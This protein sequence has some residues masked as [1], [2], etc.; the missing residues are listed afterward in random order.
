M[1]YIALIFVAIYLFVTPSFAQLVSEMVEYHPAPGQLVNTDEAGSVRAARSVIGSLNGLVSLGAYG[2]SVVYK[3]NQP[4][5]NDQNNP[6]GVDFVI[7][8]N[9][10]SDWAEPGIVMVMKDENQ[11]GLADDHW[12]ELAGSD[13][14]FSSTNHHF[15]VSY[16]PSVSGGD[17][18]WISSDSASGYVCSNS[19]H[20]QNYY[21]SSDFFRDDISEKISFSG[22]RIDSEMDFSNPSY[23]KSYQRK[24]G[25]ADN[26]LR[27]NSDYVLPDNP[28]TQVVEGCGGDAMDIGWAVDENG[29]YVDL[30]QI[31]FV[32]IYCG[33]LAN[34]GWMGEISTEICGIADVPANLAINGETECIAISYLPR[35][36][37][38]GV[39]Y[40]LEA[41]A[42]QNGR[43]V[44]DRKIKWTVDDESVASIDEQGKIRTTKSGAL[45]I[46]AFL[47][48]HPSVTAS[49]SA[50]VITPSSLVINI[51][52]TSIRIDEEELVGVQVKDLSLNVLSGLDVGWKVGD[53]NILSLVDKNGKK[54]IKGLQEGSSVL[55]VY[56]KDKPEVRTSLTISVLPESSQKNVF[57]TVKDENSTI[58][59]RNQY[60]VKCF[61]LNSF[62]DRA[63]GNYDIQ[64][65]PGITVAHAVAQAFVS[66]GL[67]GDF[68][69][70]DDEKG[71]GNLYI[72][73]V[74]K[75]D[76]SNVEYLYGYG[77]SVAT[78]AFSKCWIVLLNNQQVV[79][80]L[81]RQ[82]VKNGDELIVYHVPNIAGEWKVSCSIAN[83]H[84]LQVNDTLEVYSTELTC[85][86]NQ[87]GEIQVKNSSPLKN[88]LVWVND[89][90]AF[91]NGGRVSTDE[92]GIAT[93]RF[94]QPGIKNVKTGID[95][96]IVS[97]LQSTG[98]FPL[99]DVSP[100]KTWPQPASEWL[101]MA[102]QGESIVSVSIFDSSQRRL[103][104]KEVNREDTFSFSVAGLNPGLYI[105]Q[106]TTEQGILNQKILVR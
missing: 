47:E 64:S 63:N 36:L 84:E 59:P 74:P 90:E 72:W 89:Q 100:I 16:Y 2:G 69:F 67:S 105:L 5:V 14:Y 45:T 42:F 27:K 93:L 60:E 66:A 52:S 88:Q 38:S 1:K 13:Y 51:E 58:I 78:T 26:I 80:G 18:P 35:Q 102:V 44:K 86:R 23:I 95:E 17:I 33:V 79:S 10:Q 57:I 68:R 81:D 4:V 71:S 61:S 40:S 31:D 28:Y 75:G 19:F 83:S 9:P 30:D 55:E 6:Y 49:L 94:N 70:R 99:R 22:T 65:V 32:K 96:M 15:S 43:I 39:D 73:K 29:K 41:T 21:P 76:V 87:D 46:K 106:V 48:D 97:V 3:F 54:Y 53:G 85:S 101:N 8:G 56:L 37:V 34:A 50:E 62:V 92:E 7:F 20:K 103:F 12:Y 11:N 25:Y 82:S 24:F 77:G 98:Y 104:S 91:F